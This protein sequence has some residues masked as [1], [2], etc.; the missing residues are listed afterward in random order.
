MKVSRTTLRKRVIGV[1][2]PERRDYGMF[3]EG[4]NLVIIA[5]LQCK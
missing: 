3:D 4:D 1:S 5:N 2:T